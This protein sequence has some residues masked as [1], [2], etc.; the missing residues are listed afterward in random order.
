[1][2]RRTERLCRHRG[3]NKILAAAC[4]IVC[5]KRRDG[6]A[7]LLRWSEKGVGVEALSGV[8]EKGDTQSEGQRAS[9]RRTEHWVKARACVY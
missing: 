7:S 2:V 3:F 1:M 5:R 8:E 6:I 9:F 4:T